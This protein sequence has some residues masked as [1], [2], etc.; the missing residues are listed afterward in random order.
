M[1]TNRMG[2]GKGEKLS[3]LCSLGMPCFLFFVLFGL[4]VLHIFRFLLGII[5]SPS[6]LQGND[7]SSFFL[8][9]KSTYF[10]LY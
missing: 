5:K 10:V 8:K 3:V 2:R 1:F 9:S 7:V 6:V 4:L